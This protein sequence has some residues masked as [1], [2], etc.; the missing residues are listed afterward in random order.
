MENQTRLGYLA[1]GEKFK[2]QKDG[3][4]YEVM[5]VPKFKSKLLMGTCTCRKVGEPGF[6]YE[7]K[8]RRLL[9]FKVSEVS[10]RIE[11]S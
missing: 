3:V 11:K 4:I 6:K 9:V 5:S 10:E 1:F 2:L 8:P 7:S